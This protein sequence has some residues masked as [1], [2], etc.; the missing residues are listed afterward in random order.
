MNIWLPVALVVLPYVTVSLWLPIRLFQKGWPFTG[1]L[2]MLGLALLPL[3]V[4][5]ISGPGAV[6]LA[7]LG[8]LLLIPAVVVLALGVCVSAINLI[9]P[10]LA[11]RRRH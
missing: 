4:A 2:V 10:L 5:A 8:W 3:V 1:G 7:V 9:T 6:V 11:R